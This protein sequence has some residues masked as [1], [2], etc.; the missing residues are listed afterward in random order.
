[1]HARPELGFDLDETSAMVVEILS[2]FAL[3]RIE[4]GIA[5]TG[6]AGLI[7]G[8]LG[9]GPVIGLRA[10]MDALPIAEASGRPWSSALPGRMHACGHD[11]HTAML[12]G[13]A[14][15]LAETRNFAGSVVVIFQPA[16]EGGGGA[17]VMI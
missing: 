13:A 17:R 3:D 6:V 15:Y 14:K 12:L 9:A 5:K 8:K 2:G 16:E 4:T 11:G 7:R 1:L 10:D